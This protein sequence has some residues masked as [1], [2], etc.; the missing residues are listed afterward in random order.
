MNQV[1][2]NSDE[3]SARFQNHPVHAYKP[4]QVAYVAKHGGNF[5]QL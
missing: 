4:G 1:M 5:Q 3:K 2:V